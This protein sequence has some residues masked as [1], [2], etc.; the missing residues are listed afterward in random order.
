M[1]DP[2]TGPFEVVG[3]GDSPLTTEAK[4]CL[5]RAAR[6]ELHRLEA[7]L[8]RL[9]MLNRRHAQ[10]PIEATEA[11]IDCLSGAITWLWNHRSG[12]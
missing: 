8:H 2:T 10:G 12:P 7:E 3:G 9:Q 6:R 4:A 5:L 1:T 11:E